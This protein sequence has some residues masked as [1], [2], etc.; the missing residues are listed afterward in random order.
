MLW[1]HER[2]EL[3]LEAFLNECI[4]QRVRHGVSVEEQIGFNQQGKEERV[5]VP[6]RG[7]HRTCRERADVFRMDMERGGS[8][9]K[10]VTLSW[11]A[12]RTCEELGSVLW[13]RGPE[14]PSEG[15]T[16]KR[17]GGEM[18][19]REGLQSNSRS[20]LILTVIGFYSENVIGKLLPEQF[21]R[22][23]LSRFFDCVQQKSTRANLSQREIY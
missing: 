16:W 11:R 10:T 23:D 1:I 15:V 18:L 7:N 8:E 5:F 21:E 2:R 19:Q 20:N 12:R 4:P 13:Q 17:D 3:R 22:N 9:A 6:G 14:G